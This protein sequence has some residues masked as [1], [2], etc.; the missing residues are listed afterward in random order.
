MTS[1]F[2]AAA[3]AATAALVFS[4]A[5]HPAEAGKRKVYH[6]AAKSHVYHAG[7]RTRIYVSRRSWL[8]L[9]TEVLPGDRKFTDYAI[10]VTNFS[11]YPLDNNGAMRR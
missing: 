1:K 11:A 5:P 7:P 6:R 4:L 3:L 8:D 2:L 10:P 9:G